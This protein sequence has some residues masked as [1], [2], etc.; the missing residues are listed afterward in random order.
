MNQQS[1]FGIGH[2]INWLE[3]WRRAGG[4]FSTYQG[5]PRFLLPDESHGSLTAM[6]DAL[7]DQKRDEIKGVVRAMLG[8]EI[9]N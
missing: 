9:A 7:T 6:L 5:Q 1:N 3:Q 8:L 4:Q 2:A